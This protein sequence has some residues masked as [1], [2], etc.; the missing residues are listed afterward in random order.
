MNTPT[1]PTTTDVL[2]A[3]IA[4]AQ[5]TNRTLEYSQILALTVVAEQ[6]R[7]SNVI[8]LASLAG[9]D[10]VPEQLAEAAYGALDALVETKIEP[11]GHM[12][13]HEHEVLRSDVARALGVKA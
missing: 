1:I 9:T 13:P 12:D 10:T 3:A 4:A 8:A 7:I 11:N 5:G 6:L 2:R